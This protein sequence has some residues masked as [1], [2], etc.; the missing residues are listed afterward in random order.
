MA[1]VLIVEDSG[2]Q[3]EMISELLKKQGLDVIVAGDGLEG[4]EQIEANNP[5]LVITDLIMPLMNGYE[6]CRW[7]KGNPKSQN[8]PVIVCSIKNE[9]VDRYWGRKQ[10]ADAYITK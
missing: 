6:L 7:I 10:G 9:E 1:T 4:K 2:M 8:L 5:D 3:R